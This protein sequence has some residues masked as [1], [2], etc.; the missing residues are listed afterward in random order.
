M[1]TTALET[2]ARLEN[3]QQVHDAADENFQQERKIKGFRWVVVI[4]SILSSVTLYSLDNTIVADIQPQVIDTFGEL[5]KLPWLSVAFLLACVATNSIWGKIYGQLNA[6]WLYLLCVVLFEVGSAMCGAAPTMNVLI[7]GRVLAG[8]GGAGLYVGVM[9]LLSVNTTKR[10]RPMYIGMTGLTWGAG[11]V[12]GPIVGGGFA[13]SKVG[14]RWSFYINRESEPTPKPIHLLT[15][16]ISSVLF[17]A[18]AIPIYIFMIPSFD[19][20]PGV[21]Y[22][23]RLAQLDYLGTILMIGACVAG[24]MA[25]N[26]GG[27]IYPWNSGQTISC[28]VVS[29]VLFI[30]FSFQQA[31]CFLTTKAN[32]TFPCQFVQRLSFCILFAQTASVATVFFIP[33]Y[34][35][36]LFFQFTRN[37]SAIDAG[38]RLLPLVCFVVA[39]IIL[40][41]ALMSKF[42]Y[43]MPWY[44]LGG[45]LSLVGSILMYTIKLGTST[46]NIYGY[47]V[48]LGIGGGMYAQASFAVAQGKAKPHEIP[49]ATGF[50]S[51]AQL[52][53]GTIALAISNSVFLQRASEDIM[54]VVPNA[55]SDTVQQAVSGASSEFFDTLDPDVRTAV[56]DAVTNAISHVYILPITAAALSIG[57]AVL[58]PREKLFVSNPEDPD[59]PSTTFAAGG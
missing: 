50:I 2:E 4:L 27:Q 58:M 18:I 44:L 36:P 7:G 56:L 32:R 52:A 22:K 20:R 3:G 13:V 57:L 34:F 5:E 19:P 30:L 25:I 40:N 43:Y 53:G 1:S 14:W 11:T 16:P 45:I 33:I 24:V 59:A 38:V 10:E 28:F 8:L 9:T 55:D 17:A 6:K 21:F 31:Y 46:S 35:V 37:D 12:L 49:V 15:I 51:L 26:F 23:T 54:S 42:G 48:I 39:A 41:G 47:M 29:G